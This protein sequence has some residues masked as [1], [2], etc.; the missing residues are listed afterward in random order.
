MSLNLVTAPSVEPVSLSQAKAHMRVEH[1]ADD[2]LIET[3]IET[4]R[5]EAEG[6]LRCA[7]ISQQ[8][9]LRLDAF[10]D[11]MEIELPPLITVDS[12]S[13]LDS[14]GNSQT[15]ATSVY[16]ADIYRRPGRVT[17]GYGQSW[18]STRATPN[19]V[20]IRFTAGYGTAASDVPAD[21]RHAILFLVADLYKNRESIS[22]GQIPHELPVSARALLW[23]HRAW[24]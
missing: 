3:L 2:A 10:A 15:L 12:I 20:T 23:Q 19:A 22:F 1:T 14:D 7:L 11:V 8:W 24:L 5:R 4:A 6:Y 9:D 21:I 16:D 17:L 13:Y 18:P